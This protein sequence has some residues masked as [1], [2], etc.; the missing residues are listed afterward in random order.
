MKTNILK[1][2]G[3][4]LC[5]VVALLT[6][7]CNKN[8]S[9]SN[10]IVGNWV[11]ISCNGNNVENDRS[12]AFREDKVYTDRTGILLGGV[13]NSY[14]CKWSIVDNCLYIDYTYMKDVYDSNGGHE[15]REVHETREFE[16]IDLTHTSLKLQGKS[17][18]NV[19]WEFNKK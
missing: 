1:Q 17:Y 6:T 4:L 15:R 7:S 12:I 14:D 3:L 16:I 8:E 18:Y 11:C 19:I 10:Q 2:T 9:N 5:I 13:S